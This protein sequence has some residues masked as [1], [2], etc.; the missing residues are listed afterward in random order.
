MCL[1]LRLEIE[2]SPESLPG[3]TLFSVVLNTLLIKGKF[4]PK[5]GRTND[6]QESTL[7]DEEKIKE[8]WKQCTENL[9]RRNEKMTDTFEGGFCGEEPVILGTEVRAVL[10]VLGRNRSP[11]GDRILIELFQ[12]T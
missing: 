12:A 8:G 2:Y 7:S 6:Q 4:K 1:M 9:C 11:G 10:K 5:L 3:S